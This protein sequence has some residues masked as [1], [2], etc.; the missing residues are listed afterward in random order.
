M[1]ALAALSCGSAGA[2]SRQAQVVDGVASGDVSA[3]GAVVWARADQPAALHVE[4]R[5]GAALVRRARAAATAGADDTPQVRFSSLLAG[6]RYSYRAWF[7]STRE[8]AQSGSCRTPPGAGDKPRPLT[9]VVGADLGGQGRCR[10]AAAGGYSIFQQIT[11][12]H[13]DGFVANGDMVYA[14]N[15]CPAAGPA[16]TNIPGDFPSD[17]DVDW[18]DVAATREA[19]LGHWRY[20][21]SDPYLQALL[22]TTPVYAQW[23][24]HQV[25]NDFGAPWA[26]RGTRTTTVGRYRSTSSSA[27]R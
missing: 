3:H 25:A 21:R 27:G 20:N 2:Y 7:G 12:L 11:R 10:N 16:W 8:H 15:T 6:R 4:L 19:V 26:S 13:P 24:D 18:T 23:D 22:R 1:V 5:L 9:L 17:L 14:D